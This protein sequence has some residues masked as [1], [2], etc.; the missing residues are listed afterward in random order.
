MALFGAPVTLEDNAF[1]ACLA[2]LAIQEEAN[3]LAAEVQRRSNP[4]VSP[5][6]D[7]ASRAIRLLPTPAAP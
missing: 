5:A 1:R 2:A 4:T 7:N 3:R 6:A